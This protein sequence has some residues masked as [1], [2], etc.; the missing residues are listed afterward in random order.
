[1][2]L[3]PSLA[4]TLLFVPALCYVLHTRLRQGSL[5]GGGELVLDSIKN[6][7]LQGCSALEGLLYLQH[8]CKEVISDTVLSLDYGIYRVHENIGVNIVSTVWKH[9]ADLGRGFLLLADATENGIVWR[10]EV[11]GGPIAI[12][13]TLHVDQAGCRSEKCISTKGPKGSGGLAMDFGNKEKSMEGRLVVA[14]WGERRVARLEENGARTPLVMH[15]PDACNADEGDRPPTRVHR[16]HSLLYTPTGDLLFVDDLSSCSLL[17]RLSHAVHV[18]PLP[19]LGVSRTAHDWESMTPSNRT[20]PVEV[21]SQSSKMGGAALDW[22]LDAVVTVVQLEDGGVVL[23]RVRLSN[24][25]DDEPILLDEQPKWEEF[26]LSDHIPGATFPGSV[27]ITTKGKVFVAVEKGVA[28]V[29]PSRKLVLGLLEMELTPTSLTIGEDG[30]LYI[31]TTSSLYRIAIREKL[32][33]FSAKKVKK[34]P[35]SMLQVS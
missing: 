21:L 30:Y 13:R 11:G 14:E 8:K 26:R 32:V 20:V 25:E 17:V 28:V 35:K 29:D 12:G 34:A 18:A 5:S 23:R 22:T 33:N 2:Q 3:S 1:M 6:V 4:W 15:L 24:D 27:A 10:W 9:D 7:P 16:P 19:S 31:A